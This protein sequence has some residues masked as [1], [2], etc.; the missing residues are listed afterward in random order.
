MTRPSTSFVGLVVITGIMVSLA[1][2]PARAQQDSTGAKREK[3][4]RNLRIIP[5]PAIAANPTAGWM[6]GVAPGATWFMGDPSDTRISSLLGTVIWTTNHQWL[7]T[8]KANTFLNHDGWN[9]LTDFRYF[10]TS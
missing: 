1:G 7:I 3:K 8:A 2:V 5:L 6:F 4:V 9:L 10:I